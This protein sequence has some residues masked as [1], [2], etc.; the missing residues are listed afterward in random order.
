MQAGAQVG[1]A[2]MHIWEGGTQTRKEEQ[3]SSNT[4]GGEMKG[5]GA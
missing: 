4:I 3:R 1:E 2:N 5:R